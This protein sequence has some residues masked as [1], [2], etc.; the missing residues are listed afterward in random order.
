MLL[1]PAADG[2]CRLAQPVSQP[3]LVLVHVLSH[4]RMAAPD[5]AWMTQHM[6]MCWQGTACQAR[7]SSCLLLAAT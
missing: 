6:H 2:I 1:L 4:H 3:L 7:G 5:H